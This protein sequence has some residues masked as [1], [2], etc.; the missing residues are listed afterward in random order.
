MLSDDELIASVVKVE[1]GDKD[2]NASSY[3]AFEKVP[4]AAKQ[5]KKIMDENIFN[6]PK[7]ANEMEE[8][9]KK[10]KINISS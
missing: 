6:N 8:Y 2:G 1:N 4:M 5:K 10:R 7:S 9:G 3:H